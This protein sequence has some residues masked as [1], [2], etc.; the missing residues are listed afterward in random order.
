MPTLF[1][2]F[3]FRFSFYAN[4]H[5]PIHVHVTKGAA[6]AIYAVAPIRLMKNIGMKPAELRMI[7]SIILENEQIIIQHWNTFFNN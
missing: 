7:E 2:I 1:I 4:D 3:G 6:T 5:M